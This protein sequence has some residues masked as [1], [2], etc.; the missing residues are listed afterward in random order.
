MISISDNKNHILNTFAK[1]QNKVD[2]VLADN[3]LV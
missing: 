1:L 2:L 3:W